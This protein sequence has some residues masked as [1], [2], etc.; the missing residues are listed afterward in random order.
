MANPQLS[1][2]ICINGN[3]RRG[4]KK[5]Q[6]G[7]HVHRGRNK[8]YFERER[9]SNEKTFLHQIIKILSLVCFEG[10][11]YGMLSLDVIDNLHVDSLKEKYKYVR[12]VLYG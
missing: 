7:L 4:F 6:L 5:D 10:S 2:Y 12:Q 3:A 9:L 11:A 8:C 1:L